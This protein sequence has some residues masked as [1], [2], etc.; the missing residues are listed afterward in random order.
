MITV[1]GCCSKKQTEGNTGKKLAA[2]AIP[3]TG[4]FHGNLF[5]LACKESR[6]E[7]V[8]IS[9]VSAQL[10]LTMTAAGATGETQEEMYR[11]LR[12]GENGGE[13]SAAMMKQL[14][15][16]NPNFELKAAN[17]IWINEK[18][19]VKEEFIKSNRELFNAQVSSIPFNNATVGIINGWCSDNTNGKIKSVLGR[20]DP[21]HRMFIINALYFKAPWE[22]PFAKAGTK[23]MPFTKENGEVEEVMTMNQK[24][25]TEYF[26]NDTLQMASKP[27]KSRYEMIFILPRKYYS[28]EQAAEYLA[29]NYEKL[30]KQTEIYEVQLS[31]PKFKSEFSTSLRPSLEA[32]GMKRAFGTG[33][34]FDGITDAPLYI[35]DVFQKTYISVDEL[36]AEAAA[37]TVVVGA[38]MAAPRPTEKRELKLDRPFIYA[39]ADRSTGTIL[40][41]GKVGNP[42]GK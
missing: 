42:N 2:S 37:V 41:I 1:S 25:K 4:S 35:D 21:N 36:G 22:K 31:L 7:N 40:F 26:E 12:L 29:L 23:P 20:I 39:I 14:G 19:D 27:F 34:Q 24:F 32:M 10:A 28:T 15:A 5:S 16:E 13:E 30:R 18:F 17:S 33:A 11:A 3:A 8:C 38:L 9:P 6:S